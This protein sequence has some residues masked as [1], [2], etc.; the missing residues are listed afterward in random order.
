MLRIKAEM[1]AVTTMNTNILQ[2]LSL[3]NKLLLYV[4]KKTI[5]SWKSP[6]HARNFLKLM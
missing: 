4:M 3:M 2:T 5:G 1:E 6:K